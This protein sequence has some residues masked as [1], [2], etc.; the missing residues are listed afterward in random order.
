MFILKGTSF[1][2]MDYR[3]LADSIIPTT[4]QLFGPLNGKV[5]S[6]STVS[7]KLEI[8]VGNRMN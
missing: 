5:S 8:S 7:K 3:N 1:G 4:D 6:L 2:I